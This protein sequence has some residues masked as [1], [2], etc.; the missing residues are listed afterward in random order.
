[1]RIYCSQPPLPEGIDA[2]PTTTLEDADILWA[3]LSANVPPLYGLPRLRCVVTPT[4]GIDHVPALPPGCQLLCL[5]GEREFLDTVHATAELTLGLLLAVVRQIPQAN[6]SLADREQFMGT[7]LHGL[8]CGII[9]RGRV[10]TQFGGYCE[11]LGMDVAYT[12][13]DVTIAHLGRLLPWAAVVSI[14]IPLEGNERIVDSTW[15]RQMKDTA[16]FLN[17]SRGGIVDNAALSEFLDRGGRAGIDTLT[18]DEHATSIRQHAIVT[19]HVGGCTVRSRRRTDAF[20]VC[21]INDWIAAH[22]ACCST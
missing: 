19:P 11:A 16:I 2:E 14:H 7:E 6:G 15:F 21:K 17:T 10:G 13:R 5:R 1:M 20:M 18:H 3:G 4:T 22:A 12:D 8:N 9:G